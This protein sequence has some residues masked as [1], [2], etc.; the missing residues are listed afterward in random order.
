VIRLDE[1]LLDDDRA[2]FVVHLKSSTRT[3]ISFETV[4]ARLGSTP[5]TLGSSPTRCVRE[6]PA[7]ARGRCQRQRPARATLTPA[8]PAQQSLL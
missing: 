4:I 5:V 7:G 3:R 1:L 8:T 6:I 2:R